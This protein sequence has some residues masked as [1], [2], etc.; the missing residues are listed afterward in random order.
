[1]TRRHVIPFLPRT[2]AV[3]V[4][5][6]AAV[7]GVLGRGSTVLDTALKPGLVKDT[8]R[9]AESLQPVNVRQ[10]N[11][12]LTRTWELWL[13]SVVTSSGELTA[14][15]DNKGRVRVVNK[16][17]E[18]LH[19]LGEVGYP[20]CWSVDGTKLALVTGTQVR[21]WSEDAGLG[22]AFGR[23]RKAV[24][25]IAFLGGSDHVLTG[26]YDR[27]VRC[28]DT[29][30]GREVGRRVHGSTEP[31]SVDWRSSLNVYEIALSLDGRLLASVGN[32]GYIRLWETAT[33]TEVGAIHGVEYWW[34]AHGSSESWFDVAFAPNG[35]FIAALRSNGRVGVWELPNGSAVAGFEIEIPTDTNGTKYASATYLSFTPDSACLVVGAFSY[36][37]KGMDMDHYGTCDVIH[38]ERQETLLR[39]REK[40]LGAIDVDPK[41]RFIVC[42]TGDEIQFLDLPSY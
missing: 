30:T 8:I 7:S 35:K 40:R 27:T 19:D 23:H 28:W 39:Y 37:D 21:I 5:L 36:W 41:G 12:L 13:T 10:R 6:A 9:P 26:S 4:G 3:L 33:G 16:T 38:V 11:K 42:I 18:V 20:A 14:V 31:D 15:G 34:S 29:V 32:D 24:S 2:G 17:G 25:G 1:M 22:S